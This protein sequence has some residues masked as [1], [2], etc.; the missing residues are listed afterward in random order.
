[1]THHYFNV[2]EMLNILRKQDGFI[3]EEGVYCYIFNM[4]K[5]NTQ[6]GNK[7]KYVINFSKI[8]L[9]SNA[10]GKF[11]WYLNQYFDDETLSKI[12]FTN[13]SVVQY[14]QL[15]VSSMSYNQCVYREME[16]KS[17]DVEQFLA[18]RPQIKEQFDSLTSRMGK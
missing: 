4:I 9:R 18:D 3:N 1:M 14:R 11:V 15:V 8:A 10:V 6:L 12:I 2:K 5:A 16:K 7:D 13:V 17:H